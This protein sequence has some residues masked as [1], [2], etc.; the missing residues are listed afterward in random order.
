MRITDIATKHRTSIVV[1]TIILFIGG[2]YS[3]IVLPKESTPSI[4]VPYINVTTF[5]PG[6]SPDDVAE[7]ITKEIEQEI[8]GIT[9]IKEI[10]STSTEG[11]SSIVVEFHPDVPIDDAEQEVRDQVDAAKPDLPVD[12]EDPVI[13]EIDT[14]EFPIMT[15]NLAASY[16]LTRLKELAEDLRDEIE[17]VPG[18]L[19][20]DVVGGLEREVQVDV[21]LNSLLGYGLSFTDIADAIRDE[22]T[23]IPGGSFDLSD[24]NYLVRVD[25][26]FSRPE[27]IENFVV[28]APNG[29]PIY[30]KDLAEVRFGFKDRESYARLKL[31]QIEEEGT[32]TQVDDPVYRQVISLNVKKRSGENIL[33]T[34]AAVQ[35]ILDTY[36]MPQ[37]TF[38]LIT[39]DQSEM[40]EE[41][42]NDLENNIIAGMIFVVLVLL[43]FLGVRNALLVG[44]AIPMSMMTSFL[45]LLVL[46]YTLNFII[47]FSLII[48]LGMLV[49]NAI[50]I[51]ENI[52]RF[53]EEGH[54]PWEAA[55][56][57]TAEVGAAVV[58]STAT[59]VAAFA[60]MLFWPGM[61]GEFMS[62]MPLTLIVTLSASLFV[63]LVIN[64]VITGYLVRVD[65]NGKER[66]AT[67]RGSTWLKR[68][69]AGATVAVLGLIALVN[70][71]TALVLGVS[72]VIVYLLY[73][74]L[75]RP[76]A[77]GFVV[78]G[79]PRLIGRYR[80][81]LDWMLVRDYSVKAA[82][83]RNTGALAAFSGG[84]ILLLLGA[85]L[86]AAAGM[87]A[88][89]ALIIP[90]ALLAGIGLLGIVLHALESLYI[91]GRT[92]IKVAV[93]LAL[94]IGGLIGLTFLG[95]D[96]MPAF[97]AGV[98][99]AV[100]AIIGLFGILGA[101]FNRRA[102]LI[103]TD[104]RARLL[105]GTLAVL[106]TVLAIFVFTSAG[107]AF[108]PDTDPNQVRVNLVA[109]EGTNIE[110][111]N[112]IAEEAQR[113]IDDLL[114]ENPTSFANVEN[115]L[116][117]VGAGGNAQFGATFRQE[118]RSVISLNL[119]DFVDR[120]EP[121][122]ATLERLRRG[123]QGI[124]GVEIDIDKDSHGP[125]TGPPVNIEIAGPDFDE[126]AR[127]AGEVKRRLVVASES[128]RIPGLVD[129]S[130]SLQMGRPEIHV[131]IDRE[132]A[133]QFGLSTKRIGDIVR[134][135]IQGTEATRWRFGDEE[136]DVRVRLREEDRSSPR[137]LENL[138][139]RQGQMGIP[140]V[141][142]ADVSWTTGAGAVTH[143]DLDPV[144]TVSA[145]TAAGF[146]SQAVLNQVR[147]YLA[148]FERTMP[149][150]YQMRYTGEQ[151]EQNEAFSFLTTALLIGI[152]LIFMILIAQ[153]NSV[154]SPVLIM[155]AVGLGLIGVLVGLIVT[156]TPFSLFT[157]I[158]VISLAGIIVNN[159]IV[160]V[161][162]INQLRARGMR[163][164]EAIVEAGAT[165][166]RPV[167]L[168]ALTTILGLVPLTFGFN[169]D[170]VGLLTRLEP[171]IQFGSQNTQFWGPMGIAIISGLAFGTFLTL[172]VV[173]VIYSAFDSIAVTV[174]SAAAEE[175][176]PAK[177]AA[178][179]PGSGPAP[180][181]PGP[182]EPVEA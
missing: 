93:G 127:L 105:T 148:D 11:L 88:G 100:P 136:Y 119:V 47:L 43:F 135:A 128:R 52:Y 118:E 38:I 2:L 21:D 86:G 28:A 92:S 4:E 85:M 117:N 143:L 134:Q 182:P 62:F 55:R 132:R 57:G 54:P 98:L 33:E 174:T 170:F 177:E 24:Q 140:L 12:A 15:V 123:L 79:L 9:G 101:L 27:E 152:A 82:M 112:Q 130:D 51:V 23:N 14:S 131:D 115:I 108:F 133:A 144:V 107:V 5:Y 104:N 159:N 165:R 176:R 147:T 76:V 53:R 145:N 68:L 30:V 77:D 31:I 64:P 56:K 75:L 87:I 166:L 151:Q 163:R 150:G 1:L 46:G 49:D 157:F 164:R 50:V 139:L 180:A 138:T 103:L 22:N 37:G 149:P 7:L 179:E 18:I 78:N 34:A 66:T 84:V 10:R 44:L 121:G 116:V 19:E 125:P 39:G 97:S 158:G 48:A 171:N 63:A 3:Y 72:G 59:T 81:F 60:P 141:A 146:N 169:I 74:Y 114:A 29:M 178:P 129:V 26:R 42:V 70:P 73:R 142:I 126:A 175:K 36:P 113:R 89:L 120:S 32:L 162:Y 25:G 61:I 154:S 95:T 80:E 17:S 156:G 102:Y 155:I 90:G 8:K 35:E 91:G 160:L 153:F 124:P 41:L 167:M 173:P 181:P 71:I 168:T 94:V 161:D 40:V 99:L 69:A 65:E 111:S 6:A 137:T 58:A 16:S 122:P 67:R 13:T 109:P 20:V 110:A 172:V 45:L 96:P 83:L 106:F